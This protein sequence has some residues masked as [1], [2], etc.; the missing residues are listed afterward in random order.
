MARLFIGVAPGD[1]IPDHRDHRADPFGRARLLRG[2]QCAK[3]VHVLV[4]PADRLF[5][6]F[7]D[8][9]L[10]RP[11]IAKPLP[12]LRL[13][14]DLVVDVGEV[15]HIGD[16]VRP[17]DMAQEPEK[18]VEDDDGPGVAQMRAVI[19]G[20]PADI[21]PHVIGVDRLEDIL[22]PGLGIG[23]PDGR[24]ASSFTRRASR[25]GLSVFSWS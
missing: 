19:D 20:R 10:Q 22:R 18:H 4:I 14:V 3:R 24:H 2:A 7:A 8:Q 15:A 9:L 6:A 17:V 12:P 23:Q 11:R 13:G 16:M 21:H 1:Q 25:G 5:G